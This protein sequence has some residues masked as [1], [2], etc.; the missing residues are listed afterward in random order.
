MV[1]IDIIDCKD[2]F[3]NLKEEG[4]GFFTGVPDSLLKHFCNYLKDNQDSFENMIVANEG[5]AIALASGYHMATGKIPVVYMQ[6]SGEGN[7]INPI[8]SLVDKDVYN[9]PVL[10]VIGWRGEPDT[11]DE[12]QH[13]KQ[14]KI[15]LDLLDILD[16]RYS[17]IDKDT[18]K[19]NDIVKKGLDHIR[20]TNEPYALVF[21]KGTFEEYNPSFNKEK[22]IYELS[23]EDALKCI[24]ETIKDE[25]IVSTTGKLSRELF[26]YRENNGMGHE[27][28]F[29]TVGSMGH[30]SQIALGIA[31]N[32]RSR[33]VYCLD[34]DGAFIMHMGGVAIIGTSDVENYKHIVFN[35]GSHDSVGGQK[36]KGF[37]IDIT[38]IAK[39]SG[40]KK[41]FY[42]DTKDKLVSKINEL[43]RCKGPAILEIRIKKGA[44]KDLGRPTRTPIENKEDFMDFINQ[45]LY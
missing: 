30:C 23:R 14:G 37:E 13:K 10:L 42:A 22:E 29:L 1:V 32:K 9:I 16:I 2:F 15:T 20:K 8:A 28:D 40:Y 35:N 26:E 18:D 6:N 25:I 12:P 27:K 36:T 7:I 31:M 44:R 41:V 24:M 33:D 11:K 5:N 34:G 45:E 3:N 21:R 38:G 43:K 19:S 39:Y 17:I 4:I